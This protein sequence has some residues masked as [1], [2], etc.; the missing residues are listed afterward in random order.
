[1][2]LCAFKISISFICPT[3]FGVLT[4]EQG[5]VGG[6]R[7][8]MGEVRMNCIAKTLRHSNQ[9]VTE[10]HGSERIDRRIKMQIVF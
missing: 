3:F 2:Y 9:S 8:L 4:L 1:M 7:E 10:Q 6:N 5:S